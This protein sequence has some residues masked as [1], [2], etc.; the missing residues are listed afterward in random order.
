MSGA[1]DDFRER[2]AVEISGTVQGVGFRPFVVRLATELGLSGSV[3]NRGRGVQIEIEGPP[4]LHAAFRLAL[5]QQAPPLADIDDVSTRTIPCSGLAGFEILASQAD[6]PGLAAIPPDVGPCAR[7]L[8]EI[9]DPT[10]RRFGYPFTCCTDCGPRY[11]VIRGIP[12]DRQRTSMAPFGLCPQCLSEYEDPS[13][14]RFHAQATCCG[15]CGPQLNT[16]VDQ[17]VDLLRGG[18]VLAL[19]GLGGYQLLCRADQSAPVAEL[20][21]RKRRFE[22]PFAVLVES[23]AAAKRLVVLDQVGERALEGPE[24][25]IVLAPE[26]PHPPSSDSNGGVV[27]EVAPGTGLLGVMLPSTPL[28]RLLVQGI[29]VPLVCTSGN[30]SEEPITVD[31]QV[32]AARLAS[33][34]DAFVGHDREIERRADDSVG[35]V[36]HGRFQLLRRARGFAPRPVALAEDGPPILAVGAELKS[37]VCF[38]VG[39]KAAPSVHLG[40]LENPA[41]MQAFEEAIADQL[42]LAGIDPELVV[43]DLHPEYLSTKFALSQDVAPTLAVQHHHAHLASCLADN[44]H[45]GPAIGITFDGL[46]F[47]TDDTAWGGEVLIGDAA[48]YVRAAHLKTVALPGGAAALREPWR[49]AVAHLVSAYEVMTAADLPPLP[50]L[51]VDDARLE[52]IIALCHSERSVSTSS[53]GRLFDAVAALCGLGGGRGKPMSYEG[54]AAIGLEQLGSQ[55]LAENGSDSGYRWEM[56]PAVNEN[57]TTAI[58][59]ASVIRAIVRDLNSGVTPTT[60]AARFHRSVADLVS[61]L[62]GQVRRSHGLDVVALTGGV[63]Q[64]RLL[65]ELVVPM[66]ESEGFDVLRHR[67]VPPND[68]GISLGQVAIGRAYLARR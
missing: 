57:Q 42:A 60:I 1:S 11:T 46:G 14:R 51:T 24:V 50:G 34:A 49:M 44:R 3:T 21:T 22:K 12:Y 26:R 41:T 68:G 53:M 61:S 19:K 55:A 58:D 67:Q 13:D 40:D 4:Q 47:G 31:D 16:T 8:A 5:E 63:F 62:C 27:A 17:A 7:C 6:R 66:L 56:A 2:Q 65:V 30:R 28:H 38:A 18:A 25:P 32:A 37:M 29:G 43:H 52:T 33:I 54:Q 15:D 20:R 48:S 9:S 23:L 10:N 45:A 64:N 59:S 36:V 39:A 35:Q